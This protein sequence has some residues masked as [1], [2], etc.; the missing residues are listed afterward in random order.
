MCG[1]VCVGCVLVHK[2]LGVW[3]V[4]SVCLCINVWG[5]CVLVH[6]CLWVWCVCALM[7]V[8]VGG[9]VCEVCFGINVCVWVFVG[10]G[11][12]WVECVLVQGVSSFH[13]EEPF[14]Q[15][16]DRSHPGI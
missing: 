9:C 7:C 8:C 14:P 16:V 4:W 12:A 15:L 10:G 5:W 2:C 6:K 13:R 3:C 1:G 11:G